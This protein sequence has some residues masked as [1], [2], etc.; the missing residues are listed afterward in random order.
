MSLLMTFARRIGFGSGLNPI[1]AMLGLLG[2]L[3]LFGCGSSTPDMSE[4]DQTPANYYEG[5]KQLNTAQLVEMVSRNPMFD[6]TDERGL[7]YGTVA[8]TAGKAVATNLPLCPTAIP[9]PMAQCIPRGAKIVNGRLSVGVAEFGGETGLY[10]IDK[11][12]IC[13]SR[14]STIEGCHQLAL[15]YDDVL[16]V[17]TTLGAENLWIEHK[18]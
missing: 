11:A 8:L 16:E 14:M 10:F 4:L 9:G 18:A 13:F 6:I 1:S 17:Q 15:R 7:H 3:A 12:A 2:M 5:G